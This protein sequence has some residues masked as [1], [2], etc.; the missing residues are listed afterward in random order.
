MDGFN[1]LRCSFQLPQVIRTWSLVILCWNSTKRV[2]CEWVI[3]EGKWEGN[4]MKGR[5]KKKKNPLYEM[6]GGVGRVEPWPRGVDFPLFFSFLLH[7]G[8]SNTPPHPLRLPLFSYSEWTCS[9]LKVMWCE[10]RL[11][12]GSWPASHLPHSCP[13]LWT[14]TRWI[15]VSLWKTGK[16]T[17]MGRAALSTTCVWKLLFLFEANIYQTEISFKKNYTID[18]SRPYWI[19]FVRLG[20]SKKMKLSL[21]KFFFSYIMTFS[22]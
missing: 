6:P 21:A 1:D 10:G 14:L 8:I 16:N 11:C 17:E 22:L 12:R 13:M 18:F 4:R 20:N 15:S 2:K 9:A 7:K 19:C 5:K 3:P